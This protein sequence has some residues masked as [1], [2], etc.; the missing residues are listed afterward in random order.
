[1][2][3]S[4]TTIFAGVRRSLHRAVDEDPVFAVEVTTLCPAV[5]VLPRHEL[6]SRPRLFA[7]LERALGL[8]FTADSAPGVVATVVLGE[9]DVRVLE[10]LPTLRLVHPESSVGAPTP[11]RLADSPRLDGALR[12]QILSDG[13]AGAIVGLSPSA[14]AEAL[15]F[16]DDC[17]FWT[18]DRSTSEEVAAVVPRELAVGET[19]RNCLRPGAILSLLPLTSFLLRVAEASGLKRAPLRAAFLI[20]DPNLHRVRYGYLNFTELAARATVEGWHIAFATIPLDAWLVDR[21]AVRLFMAS[22]SQLSLLIHGNNH[23]KHEL[24]RLITDERALQEMGQALD[25][26]RRLERRTGLVV[27][28]VMAPP[29]GVYSP[30]TARALARLG[31]SALT[32]SRPY[33]WMPSSEPRQPLAGW[34][35]AEFV[36]G[37][38]IVPRHH[39]RGDYEELVLRAFLRQPLV[40]YGHHT[41]AAQG[42]EVFSEAARRIGSLGDVS[43]MDLD[44]IARTNT[45]TFS[46]GD[47]TFIRMYSRHATI[48]LDRPGTVVVE[49]DDH[50]VDV[51]VTA[52]G[53]FYPGLGPH[54]IE[55][56]GPVNVSAR[57]RDC[58]DPHLI[59]RPRTTLWPRSRRIATETR[60]RLLPAI[61]R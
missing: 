16:D 34:R 61:R 33:P 1:M 37:L 43:W 22:K 9:A 52:G 19:L 29:H 58:A 41:D 36:E 8:T 56:G 17:T 7:A 42:V 5:Q 48:D 35:P 51:A 3:E 21:R 30:T 15:A 57:R 55:S 47:Q 53:R 23:V 49:V 60:D 40:I 45:E 32:V 54:A 11:I 28:R 2:R 20:D 13:F 46:I 27:S 4:S 12:G 59:A 25:R 39:I 14:S 6:D 24:A 26:I 38:P 44:A 18:R 50:D 31:F 10:G